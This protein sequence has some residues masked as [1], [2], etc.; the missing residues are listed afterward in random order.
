MVKLLALVLKGF[1]GRKKQ[2]ASLSGLR[3][4]KVCK[5]KFVVITRITG[6]MEDQGLVAFP[7]YF[8]LDPHLHI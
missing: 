5:S 2:A 4:S 1:R 3:F 6:V 7:G 8:E